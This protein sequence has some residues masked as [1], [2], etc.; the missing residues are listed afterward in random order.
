MCL[1]PQ[2]LGGLDPIVQSSH[3]K[4]NCLLVSMGQA[5]KLCDL[6]L[7]FKDLSINEK[8]FNVGYI[9]LYLRV[10]CAPH[11]QSSHILSVTEFNNI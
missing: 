6:L 2:K 9:Y 3:G 7:F 11:V 5:Q 10:S 1:K 4:K 8:C